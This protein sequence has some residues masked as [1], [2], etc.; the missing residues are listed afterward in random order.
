MKARSVERA[1][2][3]RPRWTCDDIGMELDG[4]AWVRA[5]VSCNQ[6]GLSVTENA[7]LS[8]PPGFERE[9]ELVELREAQVAYQIARSA[10]S[11]NGMK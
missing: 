11:G 6:G 8:K 7:W 2:Q 9:K 5:Q 3:S 1:A 4:V 10:L